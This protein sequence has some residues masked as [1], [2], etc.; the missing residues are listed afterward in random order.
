MCARVCVPVCVRVCPGVC[1][2]VKIH[3]C[4]RCVGHISKQTHTQTHASACACGSSR[5]RRG[6]AGGEKKVGSGLVGA[7]LPAPGADCEQL[8]GVAVALGRGVGAPW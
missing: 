1:V 2:S 8:D 6:R 4:W 3:I 5:E 7:P